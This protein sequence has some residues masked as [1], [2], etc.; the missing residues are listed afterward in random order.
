MLWKQEFV[1]TSIFFPGHPITHPYTDLKHDLIATVN[2]LI[3][4]ILTAIL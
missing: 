1:D 3:G 2:I 4:F